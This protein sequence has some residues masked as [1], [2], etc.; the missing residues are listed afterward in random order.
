MKQI[1]TPPWPYGRQRLVCGDPQTV[2]TGGRAKI[3]LAKSPSDAMLVG[4]HAKDHRHHLIDGQ[5]C[6]PIVEDAPGRQSGDGERHGGG[7]LTTELLQHLPIK[8]ALGD[9]GVEIDLERLDAGES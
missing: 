3:V 6:E 7:Q 1:E 2:A 9:R 4:S 8:G 5:S